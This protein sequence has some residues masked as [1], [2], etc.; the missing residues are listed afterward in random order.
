VRYVD[1]LAAES[2]ERGGVPSTGYFVYISRVQS[3]TVN[4]AAATRHCLQFEI[5]ENGV[6][7]RLGAAG[8]GLGP[9]VSFWT[10]AQGVSAYCN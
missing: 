5:G 7:V 8:F 4:R 2:E 6:T 1:R 3:A 10:S 9:D